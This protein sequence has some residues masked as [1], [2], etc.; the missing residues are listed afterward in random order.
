[1]NDEDAV[2]GIIRPGHSA[3]SRSTG[4]TAKPSPCGPVLAGVAVE[5]N[6]LGTIADATTGRPDAQRVS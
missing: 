1:M 6:L 3:V 2:F 4:A 5:W